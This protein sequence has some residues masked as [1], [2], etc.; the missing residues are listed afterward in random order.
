MTRP[1]IMA[2]SKVVSHALDRSDLEIIDRERGKLTASAYLRNLIRETQSGVG[3]EKDKVIQVLQKDLRT[4][5]AK[6]EVF[7]RKEKAVTQ[8]HLNTTREIA[9]DFV[10]YQAHYPNASRTQR[11]NWLGSRCKD[12]NGVKPT[13]I[14][15]YIV[16]EAP[17][18]AQPK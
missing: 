6:L 14:L 17:L 11:D 5:K 8:D 1:K 12:S 7:E 18:I 16:L 15:S 9:K 3:M 2:D 10:G 13:E 4:T